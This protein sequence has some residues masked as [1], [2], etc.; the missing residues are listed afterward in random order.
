MWIL[1]DAAGDIGASSELPFDSYPDDGGWTPVEVEPPADPFWGEEWRYVD[2]TFVPVELPPEPA[3]T[4]DILKAILTGMPA[5][6][7]GIPDAMAARCGGVLPD[8][9]EEQTWTL[10][11]LCVKDGTV[12]RR[13]LTGW[14]TVEES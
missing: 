4:R 2:G 14:R 12:Q 13:T 5:L 1:V 7:V 9:D 3:S 8:Y 11:M 10:G 6:T